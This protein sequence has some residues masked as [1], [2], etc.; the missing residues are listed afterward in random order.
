MSLQYPLIFPFGE[1]VLEDI[2]IRD[3][4]DHPTQRKPLQVAI[5]EFIA[6]RN[7][8]RRVEF[9]NI[10]YAKR[11]FQQ[12]LIDCYIIN[13][14]LV[15]I[16]LNGQQEV[17]ECGDIDPSSANVSSSLILSHDLQNICLII[18]KCYGIL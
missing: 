2:P 10:V 17:V 15:L 16:S 5:R 11:L 3:F 8:G 1:K 9:G 7:Q 14:L 12:F 4:E 6:F 13:Q 18:V